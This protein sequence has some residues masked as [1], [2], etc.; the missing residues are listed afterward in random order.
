MMKKALLMGVVALCLFS[1]KNDQDDDSQSDILGK[2]QPYKDVVYSGK[3]GLIIDKKTKDYTDCEKK[4]SVEF[5][6]DNKF[7]ASS[8]DDVDGGCVLDD[9]TNGTYSYNP[10]TK[11][12]STT[13]DNETYKTKVKSLSKTDLAIEEDIHDEDVDGDGVYDVFVTM[14]KKL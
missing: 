10:S 12:I 1:C 3:T 9:Q 6:S 5:R 13:W 8:Y 7:F 2:W 11:Y 4:S 14:Y